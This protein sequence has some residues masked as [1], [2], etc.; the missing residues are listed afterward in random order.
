MSEKLNVEGDGTIF[1]LKPVTS[2]E[3]VDK[4]KQWKVS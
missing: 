3:V 1:V 2:M 4:R